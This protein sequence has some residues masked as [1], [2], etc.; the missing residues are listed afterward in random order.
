[1]VC[2]PVGRGKPQFERGILISRPVPT[3]NLARPYRNRCI[4]PDS[5]RKTPRG[6]TTDGHEETRIRTPPRNT[7]TARKGS[8]RG[9]NESPKRV[10]P[11]K[12]RKKRK[13]QTPAVVSSPAAVVRRPRPE[14]EFP[15]EAP[16]RSSVRNADRVAAAEAADSSVRQRAR[17][18]RRDLARSGPRGEALLRTGRGRR[19]RRSDRRTPRSGSG[20]GAP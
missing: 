15:A 19:S 18:R 13:L 7:P 14:V 2:G 16:G 11:R 6:A 20:R 17:R 9:M 3:G 12:V 10:R 4:V 8:R 5:F 1:M